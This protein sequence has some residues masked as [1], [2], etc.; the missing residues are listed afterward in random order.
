MAK[1]YANIKAAFCLERIYD[2]F[3]KCITYIFDS[4]NKG[5]KFPN[6]KSNQNEIFHVIDSLNLF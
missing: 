2:K 4:T 3:I 5:A 6:T 1:P